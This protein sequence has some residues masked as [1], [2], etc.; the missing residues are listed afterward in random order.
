MSG[1]KKENYEKYF[2]KIA[3]YLD[4]YLYRH[5][6]YHVNFA[7]ALVYCPEDNLD[8]D[9]LSNTKRKTDRYISLD[10]NLSFIIFDCVDVESSKLATQNLQNRL[11]ENCLTGNFYF[12]STSSMQYENTSKMLNA[13]FNEL[14]ESLSA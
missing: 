3:N 7:I 6:R 5:K 14:E 13:L 8:I 10:E 4:E 12:Y 2:N 1:L 9:L 11:K